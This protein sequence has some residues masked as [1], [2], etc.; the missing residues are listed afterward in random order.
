[1]VDRLRQDRCANLIHVE[2]QSGGRPGER[3]DQLAFLHVDGPHWH[4]EAGH[5]RVGLWSAHATGAEIVVVHRDAPTEVV[6]RRP[7]QRVSGT[8][9]RWQVTITPDELGGAD[10]YGFVVHGPWAPLAGHR[11]DPSK[12]L[13]DPYACRIW[14]PPGADRDAARVHGEPTLGRGPLALLPP[15]EPP[16]PPRPRIAVRG[17]ELVLYE[18]HVGHY[19]KSPTSGVAPER[20]GTFAGLIDRLDH[21]RDLGVTAVELLPVQHFDPGPEGT[22]RPNVWGYMPVGFCAVHRPYA[23]GDLPAVELAELVAACHEVG[24]Q[25]WLDVVYNHTS[26]ED[27]FG[28]TYH[29]RGIDHASY[30]V[31]RPDGTVLDDAGCG[32]VVRAAHPA[33]RRLIATSLQ[34]LADLGID[35]FRFDLASLLGR[36]E[37]GRL[38][39]RAP[40]L[41]ALTDWA[42]GRGI[43][44]VAEAWDLGAYQLG[45]EFPGRTWGQWN[46][47]YRDDVRSFLRGD[48]GMVPTLALRV[49]GS[50][51]LFHDSPRRSVNFLA[52]H[53]GF[54][55]HDWVAYDHPHNEANGH[56]GLDGHDDNRSWN[57][58]WEGELD[59]PA[60]VVAL[61]ERQLRNA[62]GL[63]MLSAGI[64]MLL[65]GDEMARTQRGNNNAYNIDDETTWFDWD[66]R[67]KWSG[68]HR[69]V[70]LV[71]ALRKQLP[72][73]G[74]QEHWGSDVTFHG[75]DGPPDWSYTSRSLAWHL[76][77]ATHGHD[78]LFVIANAWWGP[79][80]W[81]VP[82]GNWRR[83]IDTS[84]PS[85]D[86]IVDPR[87]PRGGAVVTAARYPVGPRSLVVLRGP[88]S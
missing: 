26:E 35:G 84:L 68:L 47:R 46:G 55:L 2:D 37:Q 50:P 33:A 12:V 32:N 40:L 51:D 13:V 17:H 48:E 77:G 20:R 72:G 41:D 1:M 69:F 70:R 8:T 39:Q 28:P 42:D 82:P 81:V 23:L 73:I 36:D 57:H 54:T 67:E 31:T 64:P 88:S 7:L 44:L 61:R 11:F 71:I 85:P 5:W 15:R 80:D 30:Y 4:A 6:L 53:D 75:V 79:L 3:D 83:V 43:A 38:Q 27:H 14:F 76:R 19:T 78:D 56:A 59:V 45:R 24:I 86:D 63:L 16:S 60:G 62:I 87:D 29:L 25:V 66:R 34:R 10:A 58:G 52:A 65:G 22:G 74:R 21:L 49:Q 18:L 9:D